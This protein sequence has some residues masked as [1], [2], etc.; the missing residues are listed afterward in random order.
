[1]YKFNDNYNDLE[2]VK[3]YYQEFKKLFDEI[4]GTKYNS[5]FEGKIADIAGEDEK[6]A[7]Y[8]LQQLEKEISKQKIIEQALKDGYNYPKYEGKRAIKYSQILQVGTDYSED[9]IKEFENA[10][11]LFTDTGK[12][13]AILPAR[14][15]RRGYYIY[16]DRIILVK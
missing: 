2:Q 5:M 10:S 7:I 16:P 6:T 1:M 15:S 9:S 13:E 11:I 4:E 3:P 12:L 14:C 8:L